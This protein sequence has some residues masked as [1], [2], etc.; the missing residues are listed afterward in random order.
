MRDLP[1]LTAL[2]FL[3]VVR[4]EWRVPLHSREG[5]GVSPASGSEL[6]RWLEKGAILINGVYPKPQ[7]AVKYP[8]TQ[9]VLHAKSKNRCT[10]V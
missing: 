5:H 2:K 6:R 10:L 4:D 7:D 3:E 9:L 8:I 1:E